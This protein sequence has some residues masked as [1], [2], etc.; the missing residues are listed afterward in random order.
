MK[1]ITIT[2]TAMVR[3]IRYDKEDS[4]VGLGHRLVPIKNRE[5]KEDCRCCYTRQMSI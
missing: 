1:A 5:D 2:T 3:T 4:L